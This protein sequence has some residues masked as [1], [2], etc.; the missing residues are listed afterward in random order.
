MIPTICTIGPLDISTYIVVL[1]AIVG[2]GLITLIV[3]ACR[4]GIKREA[5]I[6]L[7]FWTLVLAV[8]SMIPL[9]TSVTIYSYGFMLAVAVILCTFLLSRDARREGIETDV[10]TDLVFWIV[11]GG[12]I[13]ARFF[14]ILLN[15]SFFVDH[16][17]E[18]IMIQ[19]GGLAWQGGLIFGA[20]TA[21]SFIRRKKLFL[22]AVL[23][24]VAP[25][26]A[27]GQSIG[28]VG[29]FLNG[30]CFGKEFAQGVYFPVHAAR[31]HPTQ[32]YL[33][34]LNRTRQIV[35]SAGGEIQ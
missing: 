3:M 32:L 4:S 31:L 17:F 19:K 2:I 25:Y 11:I 8:L 9:L 33:A 22:P 27:L 7:L 20:L 10:I 6:G 1:A 35:L 30:C 23:D 12:I 24:L 5:V 34:A 14:Y 29:C 21:V 28:R 26:L 15:Y 18:V 13:G 16:P